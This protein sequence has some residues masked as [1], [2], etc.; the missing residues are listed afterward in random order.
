MFPM[1]GFFQHSSKF[2]HTHSPDVSSVQGNTL[3][4]GLHWEP[5]SRNPNAAWVKEREHSPVS[6]VAP[7]TKKQ[8]EKEKVNN[9][10]WV[11]TPKPVCHTRTPCSNLRSTLGTATRMPQHTNSPTPTTTKKPSQSFTPLNSHFHPH[12]ISN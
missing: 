9:T 5:V 1:P 2:L 10:S 8:N 11:T 3:Q 4:R 7:E 12:R 6:W